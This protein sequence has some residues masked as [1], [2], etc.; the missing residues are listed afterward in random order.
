G[1]EVFAGIHELIELELVLLVVKLSI[2]PVRRKQI[3]MRA[4][5]DDLAPF[6]HKNLIGAAN[7]REPVRD[8]KRRAPLPQRTQPILN[9]RFTL[10]IKTRSRFIENQQPRISQNRPRDCN[11]LTLTTR[12]LHAAL[13]DNRVVL[14]LKP[15]NELFT[16]SDATHFLYLIDRRVRIGERNVF[17]NCPV[18]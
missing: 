14:Q 16:M 12:Q 7:C 6:K 4:T 11:A 3:F 17:R 5:L 15:L 1:R 10:T 18:E 2:P 8:N 13:T 9:H